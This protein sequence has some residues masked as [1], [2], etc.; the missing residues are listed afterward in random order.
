MP[1]SIDKH[2]VRHGEDAVK[3][4]LRYP[5]WPI[6]LVLFAI[7][8]AA[9][10]LWLVAARATGL[11]LA[12]S[13]DPLGLLAV[14]GGVMG[15]IFVVGG[16]VIALASLITLTSIQ[17]EVQEQLREL[18]PDIQHQADRQIKA[19]VYWVESARTND[20]RVAERMVRYALKQYPDL[21]EAR[22]D[23]GT[24]L[25]REVHDYFYA[26]H[27]DREGMAPTFSSMQSISPP[28]TEAIQW[29]SQAIDHGAPEAPLSFADL[30]LMYGV[31]Q[32]YD[33]MLSALKRSVR[34]DSSCRD[35]LGRSDRL[36]MLV[37]GC[38]HPLPEGLE[39]LRQVGKQLSVELPVSI[40]V[41]RQSIDEVDVHTGR[42]FVGW[43]VLPNPDHWG[44]QATSA[45]PELL[46]FFILESE[47]R[48]LVQMRRYTGG[49]PREL[50]PPPPATGAAAPFT[51]IDVLLVRM[52]AKYLFVCIDFGAG[53][54]LVHE[55]PDDWDEE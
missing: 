16:L 39:R 2:I 18:M 40:D 51:E 33:K 49:L 1:L 19:Y 43:F 14:I 26:A 22:F 27:G 7:L 17:R 48:R 47:G 41:V 8:I 50:D 24:R 3:H 23:F 9:P 20:W 10:I 36:I 32:R 37:A 34:A 4:V 46:R 42:A 5:S 28:V 31:N 54:A 52:A 30:S 38:I 44:D 11:Q 45:F 15:A 35:Y 29:L 55:I 21:E 13:H 12:P 6:I 53:V 25:A